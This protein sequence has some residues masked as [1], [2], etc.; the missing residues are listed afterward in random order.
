MEAGVRIVPCH[1]R[2]IISFY[3][4]KSLNLELT[5]T[6]HRRF[7]EGMYQLSFV[8]IR[9]VLPI[10]KNG[11]HEKYFMETTS[12]MPRGGGKLG[13]HDVSRFKSCTHK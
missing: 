11:G 6:E 7:I 10:K 5:S 2:R 9:R 13:Q 12:S 4:E 1:A 3:Q 8:C